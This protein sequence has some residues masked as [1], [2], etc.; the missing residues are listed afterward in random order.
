MTRKQSELLHFIRASHALGKTPT[1]REMGFSINEPSPANV[2]RIIDRLCA[3][4][5]LARSPRKANGTHRVIRPVDEAERLGVP[6]P[7][8]WGWRAGYAAAVPRSEGAAI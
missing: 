6:V 7:E 5:F 4:G 3:A 2:S 8:G 1:L